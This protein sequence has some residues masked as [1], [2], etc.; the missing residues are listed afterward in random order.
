[1]IVHLMVMYV[2]L[3]V[4]LPLAISRINQRVNQLSKLLKE[5][6]LWVHSSCRKNFCG[7]LPKTSYSLLP[8]EVHIQE[9]PSCLKVNWKT[10]VVYLK[11]V[12]NT[13]VFSL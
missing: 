9:A 13:K 1:M 7:L 5:K 12:K 6:T 3:V 11:S 10:L 2:V 4:V 8:V